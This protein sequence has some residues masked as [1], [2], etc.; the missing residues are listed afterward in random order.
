[1]ATRKIDRRGTGIEEKV[2]SIILRPAARETS[3]KSW[4]SVAS[5]VEEEFF[6][7]RKIKSVSET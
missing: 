2:I 4:S 7:L 5:G 1:M 3:I 6:G